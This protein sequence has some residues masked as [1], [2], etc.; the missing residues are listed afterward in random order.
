M[1]TTK[2]IVV[3]QYG[4]K[5]SKEYKAAEA[6]TPG[7]LCLLNSSGNVKKHDLASG[8][9]PALFAV[10]DGAQ[11]KEISEAYEADDRVNLFV[12]RPGDV[13]NAI[14]ANGETAVI[15]SY[16]ESAGDGTLQVHTE[17]SNNTDSSVVVGYAKEAVDMS[18]SSSVDPSGRI[19][20]EII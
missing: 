7:H 13:V 11:G 2:V 18:D 10:E 1:A 14:L 16:L 19:L 4:G 20:V 12:G 8:L 5:A 9:A 15:G 17:D 6:I 3:E